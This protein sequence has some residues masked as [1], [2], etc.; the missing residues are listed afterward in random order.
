MSDSYGCSPSD[1]AS[2][3]VISNSGPVASVDPAPIICPGSSIQ[4]NASGGDTYS[5]SPT[6]GLSDPTIAD[7]IAAPAATTNYTV[8]ASGI[9]GTDTASVNVIVDIPAGTAMPDASVCIGDDIEL[10][11]LSG[12]VQSW[13]PDP[14]LSSTTSQTP[15]ATPLDTTTYYVTIVSLSLIHISE[16]TRPY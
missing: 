4:L 7:P 14:T 13:D 6:T 10:S 3:T 11:L 12:T 15:T 9:C 2:I 8:V 1:S 5:W 16:P